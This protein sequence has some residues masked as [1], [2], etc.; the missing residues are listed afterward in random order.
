MMNLNNVNTKAANRIANGEEF[1]VVVRKSEGEWWYWGSFNEENKA[2]E[3][4]ID[5]GGEVEFSTNIRV[6][7]TN[8]WA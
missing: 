4:A 1:Y 2:W 8:D 5:V 3:A 7:Y 6:L